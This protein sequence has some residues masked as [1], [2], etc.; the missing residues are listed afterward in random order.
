MGHCLV[1]GW[2]IGLSSVCHCLVMGWLSC[3]NSLLVGGAWFC[4]GWDIALQWLEHWFVKCVS[5][6]GH[7]LA[8]FFKQSP[9]GW[10]MVLSWVGH[11]FVLGWSIGLSSVCHCL[12]MGWI[13]FLNSLLVGGTWFCHGCDTVL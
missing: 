5:L 1:E 8:F 11:C 2:S 13:S 3:L 6:P 7:G 9:C 4:H 12:V 10:D